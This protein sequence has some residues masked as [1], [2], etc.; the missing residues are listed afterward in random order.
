MKNG[1][2]SFLPTNHIAALTTGQRASI[3]EF[4]RLCVVSPLPG[5]ATRPRSW[6]RRSQ[7]GGGPGSRYVRRR[8]A[9]SHRS[10]NCVGP[11]DAI[12]RTRQCKR[13][14]RE[15]SAQAGPG[16]LQLGRR[17]G[18]AALITITVVT[19]SCLPFPRRFPDWTGR[20]NIP[21]C[22]AYGG[23]PVRVS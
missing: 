9:R 13:C 4:T 14:L 1:E 5:P 15:I 7:Q 20:Q 22:G 3:V 8:R 23:W 6:I 11:A 17:A 10:C 21:S 18:G 19:L 12:V 16:N 2:P